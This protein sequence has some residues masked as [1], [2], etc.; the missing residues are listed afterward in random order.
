MTPH[1]RQRQ[2]SSDTKA[3]WNAATPGYG[4]YLIP[5]TLDNRNIRVRD[6][7]GSA[8]WNGLASGGCAEGGSQTWYNEFVDIQFN[9][10][11]T[12]EDSTVRR[13][14]T[15]HEL[16]HSLGLAHRE[17]SC[18]SPAVMDASG[19]EAYIECGNSDA[20]YYDDRLGISLIY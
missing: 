18:T 4:G 2:K 8:T 10:R 3:D 19:V 20:P 9:L 7:Y 15:I 13:I 12:P 14:V 1:D 5:G 17:S 16:G 11:L 6:V